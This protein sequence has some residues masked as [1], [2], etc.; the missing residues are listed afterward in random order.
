MEREI[1][2][3]SVRGPRRPVKLTGAVEWSDGVSSM[4]IVTNL[5]YLGCTL[6]SDREFARGETVRLTI[7]ER[8][9]LHAQIRWVRDGKAG[10]R[11]LTGDSAR[12]TR[13]ARIG[14]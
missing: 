8:G 14:V 3:W 1:S 10:A 5:S 2:D 6:S 4:A 12:D 13:R 11:F 7:P 9:K